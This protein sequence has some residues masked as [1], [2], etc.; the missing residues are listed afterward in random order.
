M[1]TNSSSSKSGL[2]INVGQ[3]ATGTPAKKGSQGKPAARPGRASKPAAFE[4]AFGRVS[5]FLQQRV[6]H[7]LFTVSRNLPGGVEVERIYSSLPADYPVG[8]RN[9]VDQTEWTRQMERGECFIANVPEEFGEHFH[10]LDAIV[11]QG[12]GAVINIPVNQGASKLGSLNLLHRASAYRG[13]VL[14]ACRE[15]GLMAVEGFTAYEK[16]LEQPQSSDQSK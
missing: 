12:F 13:D 11:A 9:Q 8:G 14:P 2:A 16:Y 10:N 1:V 6:G 4:V 7:T 3:S 15:A 5:A